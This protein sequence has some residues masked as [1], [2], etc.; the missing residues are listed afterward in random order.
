M[1]GMSIVSFTIDKVFSTGF[2]FS[3]NILV[4]TTGYYKTGYRLYEGT[5]LIQSNDGYSRTR[6]PG[7]SYAATWKPDKLKPGTT[8]SVTLLLYENNKVFSSSSI[9]TT[10]IFT[11]VETLP[12]YSNSSGYVYPQVRW[13]SDLYGYVTRLFKLWSLTRPSYSFWKKTSAKTFNI[14][15]QS[16]YTAF[17]PIPFSDQYL[18]QCG[19]EQNTVRTWGGI[20]PW[21]SGIRDYKY[22]AFG[23]KPDQSDVYGEWKY[24]ER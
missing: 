2:W 7:F 3:Y 17:K 19:I 10:L 21:S 14:G 4:N 16:S 11:T 24:I 9:S 18:V 22:R 20:L 1:A 5:K 8:Y 13:Y 23:V 12:P 15:W 6:Y